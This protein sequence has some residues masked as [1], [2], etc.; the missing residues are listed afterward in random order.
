MRVNVDVNFSISVFD[1][2]ILIIL[3]WSAYK[4]YMRGALVHSLS[5]FAFLAGLVLSVIITKAAYKFLETR[6]IIPDLFAIILMG[7]LLGASIF[8]SHIVGTL[9]ESHA[10]NVQQSNVS[11]FVGVGFSLAK[12]FLIIS[13]YML[14]LFKVNDYANFM[15]DREKNTRL[16]RPCAKFFTL[17]FPA[18]KFGQEFNISPV[19]LPQENEQNNN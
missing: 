14:M 19:K 16:G 1:V 13:F 18:L 4:G 8:G 17:I 12:Y 6:S 9:V 10:S 2:L 5:L 3:M 11:R 7:F 15:P